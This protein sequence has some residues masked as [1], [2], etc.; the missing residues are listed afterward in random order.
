MIYGMPQPTRSFLAVNSA[1][2]FTHSRR[3]LKDG[4]LMVDTGVVIVWNTAGGL[5]MLRV[6]VLTL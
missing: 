4:G 1:P 5:Y 2:H 3:I 6:S